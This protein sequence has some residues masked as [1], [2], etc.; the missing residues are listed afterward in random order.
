LLVS[1]PGGYGAEIGTGRKKGIGSGKALKNRKA[2][3]VGDS[4]GKLSV[5]SVKMEM[6]KNLIERIAGT[7][8]F[9]PE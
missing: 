8:I 2:R 6:R 4:K 9:S 7:R 5:Y 1:I 3:T